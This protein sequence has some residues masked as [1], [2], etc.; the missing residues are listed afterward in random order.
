MK[1]GKLI[2]VGVVLGTL[3]CSAPEAQQEDPG[4]ISTIPEIV[5][6]GVISTARNQTFP[7]LDPLSGQLW[8][9]EYDT[10][11]GAQ[12]ILFSEQDEDGWQEPEVAPFSGTW[13]DRAPRFTPDGSTLVFTSNRPRER[14]GSAGDMN[15]WRVERATGGWG[16]P[17]LLE[18]PVNSESDDIHP[19]FSET[20]LWLASRR[21]G[22]LGE[23]DLYRISPTGGVVHLPPPLNDEY[24]Q[25]DLWVSPDESW[26]ILAITG[27]PDG[28]GGDDLYVTTKDGDAWATPVNLGPEVNSAEY[29]YGPSISPDGAYLYFTSHRSG[30]ANVYR[31]SIK[32]VQGVL[33]G[34]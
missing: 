23:S 27:H 1:M 26:M 16:D 28:F 17:Y 2:W 9:S 31:I 8:F 29:E 12:T 32:V 33:E 5:G 13:N 7:M 18:S 4:P 11:F 6:E 25:P 30:P 3:G 22:G 19:S 14:G 10:S 15:I 21:E 24:S 34:R 20:A